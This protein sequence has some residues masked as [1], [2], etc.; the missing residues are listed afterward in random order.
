MCVC[1]WGCMG[2]VRNECHFITSCTCTMSF[3]SSRATSGGQPCSLYFES[4][5]NTVRGYV[6]VNSSYHHNLWYQQQND[7]Q[8]QGNVDAIDAEI[9]S[10]LVQPQTLAGTQQQAGDDR[11]DHCQ[12]HEERHH[13]IHHPIVATISCVIL[14]P[15]MVNIKPGHGWQLPSLVACVR[16]SLILYLMYYVIQCRLQIYPIIF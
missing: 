10:M 13:I 11:H 7:H 1:M 14:K 4:L 9:L 15:W 6:T 5:A 16:L 2:A 12:L 8:T 3:L